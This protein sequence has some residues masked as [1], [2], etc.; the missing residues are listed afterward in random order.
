MEHL[1]FKGT[2]NRSRV[3]LEL[4]VENM[5]GQLNAYTSRENTCYTLSVFKGQEA[6]AV[7]ILSDMLTNSLYTKSSLENERETIFREL[8]ETQKEAFETLIE[9]SHQVSYPKHQI[10]RPILGEISN[11]WNIQREMV[12]DY[13]SRFYRGENIVVVGAGSITNERLTDLVNQHFSQVPA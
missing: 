1:H 9:I 6:R 13:H 10:G 2:G 5:G 3:Q 4:E 8:V 12:V 7:E 11:I